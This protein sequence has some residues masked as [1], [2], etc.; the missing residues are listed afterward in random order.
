MIRKRTALILGAG[1]SVDLKY[2]TGRKLKDDII[3]ALEDMGE[4]FPQENIW[5][6]SATHSS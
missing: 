1:A 2:P 5:D 6:E 3:N 4:E